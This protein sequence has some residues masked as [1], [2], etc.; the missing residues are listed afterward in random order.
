[1]GDARDEHPPRE[2]NDPPSGDPPPGSPPPD[3]IAQ[4]SRHLARRLAALPAI[5][6]RQAAFLRYLDEHAAHEVVPILA[7]IQR[8]GR[9]GGPPFDVAFLAVAAAL[10]NNRLPY[11]QLAE[12]YGVAKEQGYDTLGH[13]FFNDASLGPRATPLDRD[14]QR[15]L[16]LGHR[17][18]L[19]RGTDRD[20]LHRLLI[21]PEVPVVRNLLENPRLVERDVVLLAARRPTDPDIQRV[22]FASSRWIRRYA[23]KR[24]LVLNPYTPADLALRL[25]GFFTASDLRLVQQSPNLP[26]IV[27]EAARNLDQ[28]RRPR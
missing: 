5:E 20:V 6:M 26:E 7:Y 12:L 11:A 25:L 9:K 19:A 13:I 2:K 21:D 3:D 27:R 4:R 15:E 28:E 1:M 14:E 8:L 18:T 17:K 23:V 10:G 22:I 16:T 24:A